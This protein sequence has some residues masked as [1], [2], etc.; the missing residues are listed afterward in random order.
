M[1]VGSINAIDSSSRKKLSY[2]ELLK[3]A[4][5]NVAPVPDKAVQF[6]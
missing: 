2:T 5:T 4:E 3:R 1:K 6:M